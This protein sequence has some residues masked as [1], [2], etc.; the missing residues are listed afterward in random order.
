MWKNICEMLSLTLRRQLIIKGFLKLLSGTVMVVINL[1][2]DV[3][4]LDWAWIPRTNQLTETET[5]FM[6]ILVSTN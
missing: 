4:W 2:R 3:W 6:G 5:S 1:T